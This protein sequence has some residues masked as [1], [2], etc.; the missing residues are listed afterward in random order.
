[1]TRSKRYRLQSEI[2]ATVI[3]SI[4]SAR[5]HAFLTV[6]SEN[7][8]DAGSTGEVCWLGLSA[9]AYTEVLGSLLGDEQPINNPLV[10]NF[11]T[12]GEIELYPTCPEGTTLNV[13]VPDFGEFGA[14]TQ[15]NY[16]F[17]VNGTLDLREWPTDLIV[18]DD[19]NA[20]DAAIH[21]VFCDVTT[22][23]GFCFP[24]IH[25]LTN[26]ADPITFG[27]VHGETHVNSDF[28]TMT[29][30]PDIL[31]DF[32]VEVPVRINQAGIFKVVAGMFWFMTDFASFPQALYMASV[33]AIPATQQILEFRNE[34]E[35][36]TTSNTAE[37]VSYALIGLGGCVML[38]LMLQLIK[39]RKDQVMTLTQGKFLVAMCL[40]GLIAMV[41]QMRCVNGFS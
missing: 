16:S 1:M 17:T 4:F 10:S 9:N 3:L 31:F 38:F 7:G 40:F 35:I 24:S 37:I 18:T 21:L 39:H 8:F 28:V 30:I 2:A 34:P 29:V 19:E 33:A 11:T 14:V 23:A 32:E 25:Y 15:H 5:A 27:D 20:F 36:L 12:V 41:S 6:S 22:T 26:E 13:F